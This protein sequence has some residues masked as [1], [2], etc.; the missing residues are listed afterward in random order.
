M[1]NDVC[2]DNCP[3]CG[4][5]NVLYLSINTPEGM[6]CYDCCEMYDYEELDVSWQL[7]HQHININTTE[8]CMIQMLDVHK[9]FR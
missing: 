7:I 1:L 2:Y 5:K 4:D 6:A 9:R 8:D 3:V